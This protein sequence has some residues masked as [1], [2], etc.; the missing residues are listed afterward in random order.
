[1]G[2]G[3]SR[4]TLAMGDTTN[5][6][7]RLQD[8]AEPDTVVLSSTTLR[9]VSGIFVTRDLGEQT[10]KGIEE[11]VRAVQALQASGVRSRLDVLAA[12][13]L[14]PFI[15][16]EQELGLLED[17]FAQVAEGD[18]QA[19]LV[20]G[21]AGIGKSRLVQAFRERLAERAHSWLECR[22]SP[23]NQDSALYPV[24]ELQRRG[25]GLRNEDGPSRKL[26]AIEAGLG[27][28]GFD[29][30]RAVPILAGL[31]GVALGD[32]YVAP[33]L[34]P[35]GIREQTL[36]LLTEWLLRLGR[37]QPLVL[38]ME[39]LHWMDPSTVELLGQILEQIPTA[40]VLLLATYRPDF[41]PPWGA[42]SQLTP[43]QLSRFT[44]AQLGD[45]VRKAAR[46]RDLPD[47]WIGEILQ[48]S[49]GVPLFAEE[50][51]RAVLE[52]HPEL[53]ADGSTPELRI[54]ETL[55]DSLMARLDALGPVKELAQ[56][57]SVLG[58]E[59]EYALLLAVSPM[60][61][62]ELQQA[63]AAAVR[64]ELFYQRG[65][66]P[67]AS[68]LFRHALIR[69]AAYESMLR[70]TRQ[71]HHG[72]V[73]ETLLERMAHVAEERPELVAH[74]LTEAG[75][76]GRA[77]GYWRRAGELAVERVANSEAIRHLRRGLEAVSRLPEGAERDRQELELQVALGPPLIA[78][79]GYPTSNIE[80]AYARAEAL[81][82]ALEAHDHDAQVLYGLASHC[83]SRGQLGRAAQVSARLRATA[84]GRRE[85]GARIWAEVAS[86]FSMLY[87]PSIREGQ[88]H[89]E[90]A[91]ALHEPSVHAALAYTFG[92]EPGVVASSFSAQALWELGYPD[93][94]L[95]GS[96]RAVEL[97]RA[98]GHPHSLVFGLSYGALVRQFRRD[99]DGMRALVEELLAVATEQRFPLWVGVG[100]VL[101]SWLGVV[102]GA[103]EDSL[104][105]LNARFG[106]LATTGMMLGAPYFAGLLAE[107]NLVRG[108]PDDALGAV[109]AATALGAQQESAFWDAE[110]H[111]LKAECFLQRESPDADEAEAILRKAIEIS[112]DQEAKSLE[113]RAATSLAR[114]WRDRGR[115]QEARALLEPVYDWF[116][117]GFDTQDLVEA[118]ALLEE[119]A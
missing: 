22:G 70:A 103:P 41:E 104:E 56:L 83:A 72:R 75:D 18:G 58:R 19:V 45:L 29:R 34:S 37:R 99:L 92:Q 109:E 48:R 119:L 28:V 13:E 32:R 12:T 65:A 5:V 50:L 97:G 107:A 53:P 33:D 63:L 116:T 118:K 20:C 7:A 23:Y 35:E 90:R 73:A 117:E 93:R 42:R 101:R 14:T 113:L 112:E 85:S 88:A 52:A 115:G 44:R 86:G 105:D 47:A 106:S 38:L 111:R 77:V 24:M 89:L 102:S 31:H 54:P 96:R 100:E 82:D 17:R 8:A 71:R 76:A 91:I 16:R 51:T 84:D 110:L 49:D 81:G 9:L 61:E 27:A 98:S 3:A 2:G 95:E 60:K 59:F 62:A 40:P 15:G 21:E 4:E 69:D 114:L 46:G 108:R 78:A 80:A 43:M 87:G 57:G 25:L 79:E 1:M 11:P 26:A 68:Y 64:E 66:P 55:Q 94:A 6:A 36:A 10:L 74:H 30:E 39:D 67:E